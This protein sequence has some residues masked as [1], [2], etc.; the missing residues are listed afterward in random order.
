[1]AISGYPRAQGTLFNF[2]NATVAEYAGP[3]RTKQGRGA[4]R[5]WRASSFGSIGEWRF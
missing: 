5:T 2:N 3:W 4:C 1:M